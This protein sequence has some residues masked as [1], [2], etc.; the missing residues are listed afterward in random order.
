VGTRRELA[1]ASGAAARGGL[2]ARLGGWLARWGRAFAVYS[3]RRMLVILL[4]GFTSGLPLPL[5]LSTLSYWLAKVGVD[6]TAIGL[7]A[8]VGLPYSFKFL[9]APAVDQVRIPVLAGL[10]GR[11]RSWALVTQLALAG[12]IIA[13]GATDPALRPMATAAAA[14]AV[15]F[16]SASQDIVVDAYRI[17]ILREPEQ[18]AGAA[19]TQL[20]YRIGTLAAGA[21]AIALSDWLDWQAIFGGLAALVCVGMAIVLA[22]PEPAGA[23]AAHARPT[24]RTAVVEPFLDFAR[25]PAW[26]AILAFAL[27]YKFG[28]AIGGVMA[29]T[30]FVKLG[31]SGAEIG[32]V[33]GV[34]GILATVLGAFAGGIVVARVGLL[35]A[36]AI[37]G[38]LQ[39]VTNLLYALQAEVGRDVAMLAVAVLTDNFTGGIG[40]AAFIAYLSS[41]CSARFTGTQYALLTSLMG[42][43]RTL[44]S[45]GGGWLA[46]QLDW[47]AFFAATTALALP[48]LLLLALLAR[49]ASAAGSRTGPGSPPGPARLSCAR[50]AEGSRS[51]E[52][53]VP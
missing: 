4:M 50:A 20:G 16:L 26:P 28:D 46:K 21:G 43:G 35:R 10:L 52:G 25:R 3:D 51:E 7:F 36:L 48:G 32:S 14:L 33:I 29:S 6:K 15:A 9:W 19:A 1:P 17:E 38:I 13:L 18:G 41:L 39:A 30:F 27:L 5:T 45:G 8:L 47:T 24:L 53:G 23:A 22:A 2:E 42:A 49:R 34:P 37:G 40:S 44:L 11:R 12:A 31:F